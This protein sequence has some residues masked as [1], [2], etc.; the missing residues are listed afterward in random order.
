MPFSE[1]SAPK[2]HCT[3]KDGRHRQAFNKSLKERLWPGTTPASHRGHH[4]LNH[5]AAV[6]FLYINTM[7]NP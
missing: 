1:H 4:F 7:S 2:I 5:A 3:V 6:F